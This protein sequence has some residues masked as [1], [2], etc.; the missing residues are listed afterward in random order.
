[1]SKSDTLRFSDMRAAFRLIGDC[2]DLG[3]EPGRWQRRMLE[4]LVLLFSVV[5]ATGGEAW[6]ERPGKTVRPVSAYSM[7]VDPGPEAAFQAY[8][9]AE[10]PDGDPLFQEIE[11]RPEKLI[12]R[13]RRQLVADADWYGSPSFAYRSAGGID[14][15]VVSV[16]QR[17]GSGATSVM[18]LNRARG[19]RDFT[20]REQR[21]LHFFHAEL[22]RLIGGPLVGA[23]DPPVEPLPRRLQQTLACLLEGDSEK[24]VAARL[25]LSHATVHQYVTALYRRFGVQSRAQLMSYVIQRTRRAV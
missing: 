24:Q 14:H 19:E 8:H 2:R 15:T 23:T 21:L 16:F 5:Q 20:E 7:S 18:A 11:K 12:T 9:S 1:V 25:G 10:G 17:S 13:T 6:W 3:N 22:G 4:G